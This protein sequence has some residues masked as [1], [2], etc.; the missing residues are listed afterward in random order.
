MKL[1][2]NISDE[3]SKKEVEDL[4]ENLKPFSQHLNERIIEICNDH[5]IEAT[6]QEDWED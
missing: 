3:D 5:D 4:D 6:V 1:I 2:I